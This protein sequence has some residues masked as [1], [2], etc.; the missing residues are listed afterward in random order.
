M[1]VRFYRVVLVGLAF[2]TACASAQR[3]KAQNAADGS[4]QRT[5]TVSGPVDLDI[6]TGSGRI[7]I[8]SGSSNRVEI[9]GEIRVGNS[10]FRRNADAVVRDIE[11]SPP[12]EQTGNQIRVGRIENE[13][14]RDGVSISY[15]IT[16]PRNATV[17]SHTGSG[18]QEITGVD[19]PVDA[20]TGSG[21]IRIANIKANVSAS[22]GSGAIVAEGIT[23]G[24]HA[25]TGSGSI[26]VDGNPGDRW[27]LDTGSGS[28]FVRLPQQAAF[29]LDAHT[30]S[31]SVTVGHPL[32]IS[33][34]LRRNEVSGKV[35]GGGVALDVRTGSGSIRI[36]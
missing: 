10:F 5:L 22:T 13:R 12:I 7:E 34:R 18:S 30:G 35:R 20:G 14:N 31:G 8:R 36:D 25:R 28:V 19:G 6:S 17:R 33:G 27:D 9:R 11:A 16:V 23:G 1:N 3:A 29:D 21:R 24:L 32:T 4:F 2:A 15:Q 26:T